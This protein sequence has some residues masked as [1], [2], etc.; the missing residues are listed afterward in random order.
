MGIRVH[1]RFYDRYINFGFLFALLTVS[2]IGYYSYHNSIVL[3][4]ITDQRGN[5]REIK[6]EIES[7]FSL[8]KD[9]ETGQRG[10]LLT[11]DDSY[12]EPY[13]HFK[14]RVDSR[15]AVLEK[16][17]EKEEQQEQRTQQ[18][19]RLNQVKNLIN[20]KMLELDSSIEMSRKGFHKQALQQVATHHGKLV[21]DQIRLL[22][23]AMK[24]AQQASVMARSEQTNQIL[25]RNQNVLVFGSFWAFVSMI[26]AYALLRRSQR[27]RQRAEADM[28]QTNETLQT[29]KIQFSRIIESQHMLSSRQGR[30]EIMHLITREAR[31]L[32]DADGSFL[33]IIDGDEFVCRSTSG[34]ADQ[35]LDM[36]I[37]IAGSLSGLC[38]A[39]NRLLYAED[40]ETDTRVNREACRKVSIRSMIVVPL[41]LKDTTIG[42]LRS[43]SAKAN[44]F[45]ELHQDTL[46]LIA[47]TFASA[48]SKSIVFEEM[49]KLKETAD[50]ATMAKSNFLANMSHEIRTPM[51]GII[52]MAHL[53]LE[54]K[55]TPDQRDFAETIAGSG[56]NLLAIINDILDFSKIE[57]KKMDLECVEFDMVHFLKE[58]CKPFQWAIQKK[59]IN[60]DFAGSDYPFQV[61]GDDGKIGQVVSNLIA[62]AVKF[63]SQGGVTLEFE[64]REQTD[65][66]AVEA[67]IRVQDTGI[68]IPDDAKEKMFQAFSQAGSTICRQYG[69][70]G[71]GLSISKSLVALMG[72]EISFES[73]YGSGTSFTVVLPMKRG[74]ER[75]E[76][77]A[78]SEISLIHEFKLSGRILVAE[79][80]FT[81]QKVISR[82]LQKLGCRVHLVANGNEA[83]NALRESEFD[84]ILMDCQMPEMDGYEATRRIRKDFTL[85]QYDIPIVALTAN[86]IKGDEEKCIQAGM[87]GYLSKPVY[88]KDLESVLR[89]NLGAGAMTSKPVVLERKKIDEL[90]E[91]QIPGE[92]DFVIEVID[93][94]LKSS[95]QRMD[96]MVRCLEA[97]DVPG[98]SDGAHAL[99]SGARMLG[100]VELGALCQKL[101]DLKG[102]SDLEAA[103]VLFESIQMN[104]NQTIATLLDMKSD[105]E[106]RKVA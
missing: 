91:L 98:A 73:R 65:G 7:L 77:P 74:S 106:S 2:G 19:D 24:T 67:V 3:Q 4:H 9:A 78:A 59:G 35:F 29:Q 64:V 39:E 37:K 102:S 79:D 100:A 28:I 20:S 21:M 69:G 42:V 43:Y 46:R 25:R 96:S 14:A 12:L 8:I 32:T 41:K 5:S 57:A 72:G 51:N 55:L 56:Q 62:N 15:I 76:R 53:M 70:T 71:L 38:I 95:R 33:E 13:R 40:I 61:I 63:T 81:N 54:T 22:I 10:F 18:L 16:N 88:L 103:R 45:S 85:K 23:R 49:I 87:T 6:Y 89:R 11:R 44:G 27:R 82:M 68:G 94:Y 83:I 99:K 30:V 50:Q 104:Y 80:N 93:S 60:F 97:G 36:R 90:E 75:I 31:H 1:K 26:G 47:G 52:G 105:R 101:E 84:L 66:D 58:V 17:L 48:W 34:L 92:S 86:A